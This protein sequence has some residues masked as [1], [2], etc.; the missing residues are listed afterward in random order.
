MNRL[1]NFSLKIESVDSAKKPELATAWLELRNWK[2]REDRRLF[3]YDQI[4]RI[5]SL[6]KKAKAPA[7]QTLVKFKHGRTGTEYS[8]YI[9]EKL[10]SS[11]A[12]HLKKALDKA[13]K[14]VNSTR[15]SKRSPLKQPRTAYEMRFEL[16]GG[17]HIEKGR[18]LHLL[19]YSPINNINSTKKPRTDK[20]YI[21]VELEFNP[22]GTRDHRM[23]LGAEAEEIKQSLMEA[24]L[25]KFCN[26]GYDGSCGHE[27]KVLL[28][29]D[30]FETPLRKIMDTLKKLGYSCD[31][32]CGGHVHFDMRN[33]DVKAVYKNLVRVQSVLEK[34]VKPTRV[35]N[36][37]CKLN[38]T[39]DF[40]KAIR[41]GQDTGDRYWVI[42]PLAF[43]S[44]Q[45]LEIRVHH[46]TL[47][48]DEMVNWLKFLLKI[49]NYKGVI[50]KPVKMG[51]SLY[52]FLNFS[53]AEKL[54]MR[55]VYAKH[56]PKVNRLANRIRAA[57]AGGN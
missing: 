50:E 22:K 42:N 37:F 23:P 32:R 55:E 5:K 15:N 31:E 25:G 11:L 19:N 8:E 36:R 49:V 46:G 13:C 2:T 39:D 3:S 48:A 30:D 9:P 20:C 44:H 16:T 43:T 27:L 14:A 7:Q 17:V 6:R 18:I 10:K 12:M 54:T 24:G 56:N 21:G 51:R 29:E 33:R 1:K 53:E 34:L 57:A 47:E 40:D 38:S 4:T 41:Y 45:T 26:L 28:P 35:N 52:K